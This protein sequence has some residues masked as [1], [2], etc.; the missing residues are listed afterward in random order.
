MV[1]V[2]RGPLAVA[3][4]G[5]EAVAGAVFQKCRVV[6]VRVVRTWAG[7]PVVGK[8]GGDAGLAEALDVS[9][10]RGNERDMDALS[11][12]MLVVGLRESE[13]SPDR[14]ARRARGLLDLEFIEHSRKGTGGVR[15]V[16]DSKGH[17]VEH[18][19]LRPLCVRRRRRRWCR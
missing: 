4:D 17:V 19:G 6:V 2:A 13:V 3:V 9:R 15:Q 10:G 12:R 1:D 7:G 11:D 16:G 18:G 14:E 8:P 5:F